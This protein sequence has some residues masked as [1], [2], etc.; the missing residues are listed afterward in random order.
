MVTYV[1]AVHFD[2]WPYRGW[3]PYWFAVLAAILI[4]VS[5][6]SGA[7][8]VTLLVWLLT[9]GDRWWT[10]APVAM[11]GV[12]TLLTLWLLCGQHLADLIPWLVGN[13]AISQ[14]YGGAMAY[15]EIYSPG[16]TV[17]LTWPAW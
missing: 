12:G 14:G 16:L 6:S 5:A 4:L 2:R 15:H 8:A 11:L 3:V 1:V 7:F 13:L 9:R 10:A 17:A